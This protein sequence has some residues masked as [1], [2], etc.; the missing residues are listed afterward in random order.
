[1]ECATFLDFRAFRREVAELAAPVWPRPRR[2]DVSRVFLGCDPRPDDA[3]WEAA[4]TASERLLRML[5][6]R[7]NDDASLYNSAKHGMT[8]I[9]GNAAVIIGEE[10]GEGTF[11]TDGPSI[12]FLDSVSKDGQRIWRETTRWFSIR[13]ALWL[14]SLAIT[15]IE[16]LWNLARAVYLNAEISGVELVTNEGIDV[17]TTGRFADA[18]PINR[19]SRN[20]FVERRN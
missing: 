15:Q 19:F 3:A 16:A 2:A 20:V 9:G 10:G 11:G 7:L 5:A 14:T 17:V 8:V 1:V 12:A 13:Q 6:A 18:K 4:A